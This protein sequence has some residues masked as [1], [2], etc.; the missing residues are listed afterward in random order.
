MLTN[1]EIKEMIAKCQKILTPMLTTRIGV[2]TGNIEFQTTLL[3]VRK[4]RL[5][6]MLNKPDKRI[7]INAKEEEKQYTPPCLA[8]ECKDGILYFV[9]EDMTITQGL[10]GITIT[11]GDIA[12]KIRRLE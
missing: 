8:L 11:T 4:A 9:L 3:D 10:N 5:S 1:Q 6:D 12:C 7:G 2:T